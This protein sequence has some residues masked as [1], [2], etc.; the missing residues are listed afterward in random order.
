MANYLIVPFAL[1]PGEHL[2]DEYEKNVNRFKKI[3]A[4]VDNDFKLSESIAIYR[5]LAS[6]HKIADNWYPKDTKKRAKVDEYLEW[7]HVS[8][9]ISDV[10]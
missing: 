6:E 10:V 5:Y 4:I 7:Q 3:P 1:P 9:K 8:L 2:T